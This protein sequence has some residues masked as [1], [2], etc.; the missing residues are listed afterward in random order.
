MT[1]R[2]WTVKMESLGS[3][4]PGTLYV[5]T[6]TRKGETLTVSLTTNATFPRAE[7]GSMIR[8]AIKAR[9]NG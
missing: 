4:G 2:G 6:A 3:V 1:F 7:L 9:G 8:E 5:A